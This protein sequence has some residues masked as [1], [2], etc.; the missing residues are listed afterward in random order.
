MTPEPALPHMP[1]DVRSVAL[2]VI[3]VLLCVFAMKWAKEVMVPLLVGVMLSYALVPAVDRLQRWRIPRAIAA[4]V[5]LAGV[6]GAAG[7]GAWSLS[8]QANALAES[9]PEVAQKLRRLA[10]K[11]QDGTPSPIA[12]VQEAAAEIAK[13]AQGSSGASGASAPDAASVPA[14][15]ARPNRDPR[16]AKP[17][18]DAAPPVVV[19]PAGPSLRDFLWTGTLGFF[20]VLGQAVVVLF[21]ALFLLAS[22]NNFRRKMVKLAGPTLAQ[23]RITVQVLDEITEQIQ[24]YL[25]VQLLVSIVVG[26]LTWLAFYALGMSQAGVWGVV[27]GVANL[28]PYVGAIATSAAAA[29][30]AAVQFEA[31]DMGLYAA[32]CS[33]AIHGVVG[34]LLTPWWMGKASRISPFVVFVSLLFFGWLWGVWGLLL[35]VPMLMVTKSICDRIEGLQPVGELLGA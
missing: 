27:A 20:G 28:V 16:D 18:T 21:I 34:N 5:V 29:A 12:K 35:G 13:A 2:L 17:K 11:W 7:W 22:G 10:Q 31:I 24:R 19:V 14:K 9:L 33:L 8:D 3:A 32:A 26:V 1:V 25:L 15:A 30:F 23:K 6:I 4:G